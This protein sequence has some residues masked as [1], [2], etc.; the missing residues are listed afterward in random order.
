MIS[1]KRLQDQ[2][3]KYLKAKGIYHINVYGSGRAAKGA[4][5]IIACING[6]FVAFE[7]KVGT[8][9]LQDDQKIHKLRIE[10]SHGLH[11]TPR[12]IEEFK[13]EV[14]ECEEIKK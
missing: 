10:R 4:P 8:N 2:C 6:L 11:F 13:K 14:N 9:D 1:E 3:L 5:D 12:T 7:L